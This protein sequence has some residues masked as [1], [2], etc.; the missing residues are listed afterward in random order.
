MSL[1]FS[2]W[3]ISSI[4][5]ALAF[6]WAIRLHDYFFGLVMADR[7]SLAATMII[8]FLLSKTIA[9]KLSKW[10]ISIFLLL[11]GLAFLIYFLIYESVIISPHSWLLIHLFLALCALGIRSIFN[12]RL[13]FLTP[14]IL[15]GVFLFPFDFQKEQ[16]RFYDRLESSIETRYGKA[17]IVQW[18][19]DY[20][21]YYNGQLQFSTIDK[22]VFQEAYVQPIMQFADKN[23]EVLLIGGDNGMVESELSK[24]PISLTILPLDPEFHSFMRNRAALSFQQVSNKSVLEETNVFRFLSGVDDRYDI[25]IIDAP[26]PLSLDYQQF[27]TREFYQF[28]NSSLKENGFMVTQSGDLFKKGRAAQSIWNTVK[29]SGFHI[30]PSQ[31]QIPTIGHWSWV[32]GAKKATSSQ[33]ME[34]FSGVED[35]ETIWWNQQAADM[36]FSFGKNYFVNETAVVNTLNPSIP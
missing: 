28:V 32:I 5:L 11:A 6:S 19:Q 31:C 12:S 4:A 29:E 26:D 13:L 34:V 23:S 8:V 22:H 14:L 33:M 30:V 10:P 7:I 16:L 2:R 35:E 36:M 15:T 21:L 27:Y 9:L 25:I 20:W 24:F 1:K 3:L 18:K 17:Q